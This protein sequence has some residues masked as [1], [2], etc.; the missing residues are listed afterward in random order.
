VH[1][2][3]HCVEARCLWRILRGSW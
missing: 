1:V 3:V 2:L